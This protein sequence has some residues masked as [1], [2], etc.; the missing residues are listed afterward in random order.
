MRVFL[1]QC[2]FAVPV[3]HHAVRHAWKRFHDR[4]REYVTRMRAANLDRPCHDVRTVSAHRSRI[5][6]R[7]QCDGIAEHLVDAVRAEERFGVASLVFED[8]LVTDR[9]D[10]DLA[11]R[12]DRQHGRVCS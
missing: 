11:A 4:H 1:R 10:R 12:I 5:F 8:A 6:A 2:A 3:G 7:C 9:V